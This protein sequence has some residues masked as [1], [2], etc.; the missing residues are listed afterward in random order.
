MN[1]QV[2]VKVNGREAG[3]LQ[4]EFSTQDCLSF[5]QQVEQCK[6]RV[7]QV[8]LEKGFEDCAAK[9]RH[10]CCCGKRMRNQG[11]QIVTINSHS[12]PITYRR[13]RY[14]CRECGTW[15]TPAD[16]MI[17][18]GK[19]RITRL[20]ARNVCQLAT[21]EHFTQLEQL[22][23]DQHGVQL[24]HDPMLN[25]V[26]DVGAVAEE[27]RLAEVEYWNQQLPHQRTWP[28]PEVTPERVYVSC[29]GI[30]Y[31]TNETE[32]HPQHPDQQRLLWKQMRVG[33]VYWQDERERWHKRVIW[34]QEE[35]YQSFGA[36][37]FR[38]AC[39]CGY[40]EAKEK[41]YAADGGDW[42]W[43]IHQH[44]FAEASGILDWY[45]ASEHVWTCAKALHSKPDASQRWAEEALDL[46]YEA[47]GEGLLNWLLKEIK[48]RRGKS[49]TALQ[50]LINYFQPKLD[51]TDY[52]A[53]REQGWQIG[54]GMIESTAKQL[55]GSRLKGPGMHWS[56]HGATAITALRA[57]NLN[58]NWHNYWKNLTLTT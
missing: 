2:I 33:C 52:P 50:K 46:L 8:I 40:R 51:R 23:S 22:V 6:D 18:C 7:G 3:S 28:E 58:K 37:L 32:P 17:R 44:Y 20:L 55:V 24:G 45:H 57:Q 54:T 42:C 9:L 34:G 5:E 10:P 27:K 38:A 47:G 36:S 4:Q 14:R 53:Y 21:V 43:G 39:Q 19:H 48:L 29:D 11:K 26:H 56:P 49:R 12:G 35:D 15:Q 25:L 30:M 13:T 16:A 1:V 31:C 41:I